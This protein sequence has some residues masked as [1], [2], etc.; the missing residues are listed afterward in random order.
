MA[1]GDGAASGRQISPRPGSRDRG[2]ETFGL[3]LLP[4]FSLM[5]F[6]SFVEPL[7][8]VNRLLGRTCY[9]WRLLTVDGTPAVASSGTK[10][11]VD[12]SIDDPEAYDFLFLCAGLQLDKF[13]DPKTFAWLRKLAR[14]GTTVGAV[15]TATL[16]LA[17]AGLLDGYKSTIHWESLIGFQEEF[18]QLDC[19]TSLFEID[20]NRITCAGAT[21][22][23]DLML[24]LIGKRF[25]HALAA[26][27]PDQFNH[28][29]VRSEVDD[30]RLPIN[31]RLG[32]G[33]PK[34]LAAVG[35]M[36]SNIEAPLGLDA[37]ASHVR[38]SKRQLSRLFHRHIGSSA[39]RHYR[40]LRLR[41]ASVLLSQTNLS[42]AEITLACGYQ[43]SSHFAK[44]Y[45]RQFGRTPV[46]E[47]S[48]S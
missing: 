13:A 22:C 37:I 29:P 41:R 1:Q 35:L 46:Q 31:I 18:P 6:A 5:T 19:T 30:Q 7:R 32:A 43:S 26:A 2:I 10:L 45:R 23:M 38:L 28:P 27:V 16:V 14:H 17:R 33:H 9:R 39:M 12:G 48:G 34:L 20:R 44:D 42:V 21:A 8:Q 11:V 47:R 15:S 24:H 25:G 3:L 36:E 40:Y 4:G